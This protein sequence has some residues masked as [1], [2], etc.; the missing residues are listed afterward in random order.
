MFF[1]TLV[2]FKFK[3][4]INSFILLTVRN[5]KGQFGARGTKKK[6]LFFPTTSSFFNVAG[7]IIIIHHLFSLQPMGAEDVSQPFA[8]LRQW[9]STSIIVPLFSSWADL[10]NLHLKILWIH[11]WWIPHGRRMLNKTIKCRFTLFNS[12]LLIFVLIDQTMSS[13]HFCWSESFEILQSQSTA[14]LILSE[15]TCCSKAHLL[16]SPC[17]LMH[18]TGIQLVDR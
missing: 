16:G 9:E 10:V 5:K 7:S 12:V 14:L 15:F 2:S 13:I 11:F 6:R 18:V 1:T 8:H 17:R 3:Y 4:S